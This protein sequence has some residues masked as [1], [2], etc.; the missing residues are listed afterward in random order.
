MLHCCLRC[1][2]A[3]PSTYDSSVSWSS[4]S[5]PL[6]HPPHPHPHQHLPL[7][8]APMCTARSGLSDGPESKAEQQLS[9]CCEG[10]PSGGPPTKPTPPVPH[11]PCPVYH[12]FPCRPHS[13]PFIIQYVRKTLV[14]CL[15]ARRAASPLRSRSVAGH[16]VG[17]APPLSAHSGSPFGLPTHIPIPADPHCRCTTPHRQW[18]HSHLVGLFTSSVQS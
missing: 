13:T 11:P 9:H 8:D 4:G 18:L 12:A 6:Q 2:R 1:R 3:P 15:S 5:L 17:I 10:K 16:V 14:C 7:H